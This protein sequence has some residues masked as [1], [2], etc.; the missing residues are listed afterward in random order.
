MTP[1]RVL[2]VIDSFDLGG[3]QE[4]LVNLVSFAD[5]TRFE[6]EVACMHGPGVYTQRLERLGVP[7]YSLSPHKFLP[8]YVLR[9]VRLLRRGR[10]DVVHCHLIASNL[11]AKPIAALLGVRV[12]FN[13]DQ[14]NDEYRYRNRLRL[15]LDRCTNRL[16]THVCAVSASVRDF[17]LEYEQVPA[18]RV[19]LIHNG[20]DLRRFNHGREERSRAREHWRIPP[21]RP[22]I[23]GVGRLNYQKNFALF[24]EIAAQASRDE[25]SAFFVIAGSGP[26]EETL[27]KRAAELGLGADRLLFAGY[28]AEMASFYPAVDFLL[29]PSRFEG[30]P[31]TLLEAMAMG[32]PTVASRLDGISEIIEDGING[33]LVPPGDRDAFAARLR[34]LLAAPEKAAAMAAAA[35]QKVRAHFSAE[36]MTRKVEA[37]Y[38]SCLGDITK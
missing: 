27:R 23:A 17:L 2:H 1:W 25:P 16:S 7:A 31:M 10:F 33:R 15:W 30:L 8:L 4:A 34:E 11:I 28:V 5:R 24:L 6:I 37:L 19:S 3:A 35:Q 36:M 13:H 21:G 22:V 9:L 38:L 12:R 14:T 26:E 18:A 20:I 32:V 29:M